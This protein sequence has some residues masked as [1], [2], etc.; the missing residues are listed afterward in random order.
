[1]DAWAKKET[2]Q[3]GRF[4]PRQFKRMKLVARKT[5]KSSWDLQARQEQVKEREANVIQITS[6]DEEERDPSIPEVVI[7]TTNNKPLG[8]GG[9]RNIELFSDTE[10]EEPAR[11]R[12]K[13]SRQQIKKITKP[14]CKS[15]STHSSSKALQRQDIRQHLTDL[16][17]ATS[18]AESQG[19]EVQGS[20]DDNNLQ[21]ESSQASDMHKEFEQNVPVSPPKPVTMENSVENTWEMMS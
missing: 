20:A 3:S 19:K 11:K 17:Q 13:A 16:E 15:L 1:M 10:D 4:A 7:T 8:K 2:L 5:V 18:D 9:P 14:G 6:D 21:D 12:H